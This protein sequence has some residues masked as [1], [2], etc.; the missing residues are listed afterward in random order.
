MNR[1]I[2]VTIIILVSCLSY[3]CSNE[4]NEKLVQSE[5]RKKI[6]L[7]NIERDKKIIESKIELLFLKYDIQSEYLKK[8]MIDYFYKD[9]VLTLNFKEVPIDQLMKTYS[10]DTIDTKSLVEISKKHK[11]PLKTL[12][13][14]VY[15]YFVLKEIKVMYRQE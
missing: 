14:L 13:S 11:I 4:K 9:S 15:D 5:E 6:V 1:I 2:V 12:S 8:D 3:S 7:Q 10:A